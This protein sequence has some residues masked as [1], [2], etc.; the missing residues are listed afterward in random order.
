MNAI[1]RELR[2]NRVLWLLAVV[3]VVFVVE[4]VAAD[5]HAALG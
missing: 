1:L 2:D 4:Q 5:A 3:P